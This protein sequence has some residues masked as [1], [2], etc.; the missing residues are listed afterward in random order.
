L[1]SARKRVREKGINKNK[2]KD[3][4]SA[5][6]DSSEEKT[7]NKPSDDDTDIKDDDDHDVE[8]QEDLQD[9]QPMKPRNTSEDTTTDE[10]GSEQETPAEAEPTT[11]GGRALFRQL[12]DSILGSARQRVREKAAAKEAPSQEEAAVVVVVEGASKSGGEDDPPSGTKDDETDVVPEEEDVVDP[13]KYDDE[14]V[15]QSGRLATTGVGSSGK[16]TQGARESLWGTAFALLSPRLD[17]QKRR[18]TEL[19]KEKMKEMHLDVDEDALNRENQVQELLVQESVEQKK[20][21]NEK[22]KEEI[23]DAA[24]QDNAREHGTPAQA[25][26]GTESEE[27][28]TNGEKEDAGA[29]KQSEP[30]DAEKPKGGLFSFFLGQKAEK[31]AE[32][33]DTKEPESVEATEEQGSKLNPESAQTEPTTES[34]DN[35]NGTDE[36]SRK[37]FASREARRARVL[38]KMRDLEKLI[39]E[40]RSNPHVIAHAIERKMKSMQSV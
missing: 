11:T 17:K 36:A 25:E 13:T 15:E 20:K 18:Q 2:D 37:R 32:K 23:P 6:Q 26:K 22:V 9:Q 28:L 24:A 40:A 35:I 12:S 34:I 39:E 3:T 29:G 27:K 1:G 33:K 30:K 8:K 21:Q 14:P 19:L 4:L 5:S 31:E 16:K 10:G 7:N 38:G